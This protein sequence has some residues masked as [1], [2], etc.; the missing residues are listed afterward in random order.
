MDPLLSFVKSKRTELL[1]KY[2]GENNIH[3]GTL[4]VRISSYI[5]S[6]VENALEYMQ[7]NASRGKIVIKTQNE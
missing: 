3:I 6:S 1:K 7:E 4:D 5:N 2:L